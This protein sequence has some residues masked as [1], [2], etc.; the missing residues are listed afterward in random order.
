MKELTFVFGNIGVF[1]TAYSR[2]FFQKIGDNSSA[3]A[4]EAADKY[5]SV[6]IVM[7]KCMHAM[8]CYFA[9]CKKSAFF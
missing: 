8:S 6:L 2:M 4:V 7:I 5:K 3:A 9:S 1:K